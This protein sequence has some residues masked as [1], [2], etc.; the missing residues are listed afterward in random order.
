MISAKKGQKGDVYDFMLLSAGIKTFKEK[1]KIIDVPLIFPQMT[2]F[3][4]QRKSPLTME[5]FP[6]SF[7]SK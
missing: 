1:H 7:H 5:I 4:K 6:D 2:F 3:C